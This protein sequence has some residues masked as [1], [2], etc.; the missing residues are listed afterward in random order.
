MPIIANQIVYSRITAHLDP[1]SA[2]KKKKASA[3]PVL[4]CNVKNSPLNRK[5]AGRL[6]LHSATTLSS[7]LASFL[8]AP[9][10]LV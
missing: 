6:S 8:A 9:K 10:C 5:Q 1:D 7:T 3:L 4:Q 2:K